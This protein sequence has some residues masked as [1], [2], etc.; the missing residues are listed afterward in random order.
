VGNK[1]PKEMI[2][3]AKTMM[4]TTATQTTAWAVAVPNKPSVFRTAAKVLGSVADGIHAARAYKA[5]TDRGVR[6]SDAVRDVFDRV[7]AD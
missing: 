6:P 4:Q 5:L 2:M 1:T 3:T 7:H